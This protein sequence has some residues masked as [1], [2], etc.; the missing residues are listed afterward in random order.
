MV[1][2]V[3]G[4]VEGRLRVFF[5][6]G[7]G[8]HCWIRST[9]SRRGRYPRSQV[10]GERFAASVTVAIMSAGCAAAAVKEALALIGAFDQGASRDRCLL[11]VMRDLM[12][13]KAFA[14]QTGD[15]V[16]LTGKFPFPAQVVKVSG[17]SLLALFKGKKEKPRN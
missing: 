10:Q 16:Y 4:Q 7:R 11:A 5:F 15:G 3:A 13:V 2:C 12:L 14:F 8:A 9:R 6:A 1:C 17:V